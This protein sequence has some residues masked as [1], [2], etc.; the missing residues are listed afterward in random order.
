MSISNIIKWMAILAV[1]ALLAAGA[2][3]PAGTGT[4]SDPP[5]FF[6][7]RGRAHGVGMCMDG[8]LYRAYDGWNYHDIIN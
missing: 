2:V 1:V 8:A 7:G 4:G 6:S 3:A 5:Y